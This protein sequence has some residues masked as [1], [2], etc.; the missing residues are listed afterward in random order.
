ME[1]LYED[2]LQKG[3]TGFTLFELQ[4]GDWQASSRWGEDK[5]WHVHTEPS[6][7]AAVT[8]ALTAWRPIGVV[9]LPQTARV[10]F[11]A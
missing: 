11:F 7:A 8:A 1:K 9:V 10:D 6:L 2:A 3:L 5:A 4:N